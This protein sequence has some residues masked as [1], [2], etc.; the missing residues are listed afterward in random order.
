VLR[1]LDEEGRAGSAKALLR[2]FAG[3]LGRNGERRHGELERQGAKSL[4]EDEVR[5]CGSDEEPS[6]FYMEKEIVGRKR[7]V[8]H[9]IA[10][11]AAPWH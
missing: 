6:R 1:N 7:P 11:W 3:E 10:S 8:L 2:S 4:R 9:R 5:V